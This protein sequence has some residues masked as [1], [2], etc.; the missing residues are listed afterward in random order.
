MKELFMRSHLRSTLGIFLLGLSLLTINAHAA[1]E[2]VK[3]SERVLVVVSELDSGGMPELTALYTAL[4]DLTRFSTEGILGAS[5]QEIYY[6]TNAGASL[7]EFKDKIHELADDEKVKAIDVIMSLH[8]TTEKLLFDDGLWRMSTIAENFHPVT[9]VQDRVKKI[10]RKK[11]MRMLYNLSCFGSS[12][13]DDFIS[14]GFDVV[15]GSMDVNA[16]SAVEYAPALV[17]WAGRIG[18]K[19]SFSAS[20]NDVALAMNDAPIRLAGQLA[21]NALK[22]TNSKKLFSAKSNG[23][24][25]LKIDEIMY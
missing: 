24:V 12:H 23:S 2:K 25:N 3:K 10:L 20:N 6:L 4:E 9:T 15:N 19:D 18:F 22:K 8:G 16:N 11:K 1:L 13:R 21:N 14:M 7:S 17:A 5:Y